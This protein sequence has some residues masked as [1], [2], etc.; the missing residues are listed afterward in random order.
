MT[1]ISFSS[2]FRKNNMGGKTDWVGKKLTSQSF[3]PGERMGRPILS[4]GKKLTGEKTDRYT[5]SG[6]T[7]C[8][9]II[10]DHTIWR[11]RG[12]DKLKLNRCI[13]TLRLTITWHCHLLVTIFNFVDAQ[14]DR[15]IE[16]VLLSTLNRFWSG[17]VG[18]YPHFT[19]NYLMLSKGKWSKG[20]SNY[21]SNY[22]P[23][24]KKGGIYRI[25]VVWP[26]VFRSY[27]FH[28]RLISW[29]LFYRIYPNFVCALIL[30][31][32]SL[33]LLH[34]IFPKFVPELRPLINAKILFQLNI[35]RTNWQSFTN[36]YI[37]I[38]ID[39]I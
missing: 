17:W 30:A 13:I 6:Q 9:G 1:H 16:T 36:F 25:W 21:L 12:Y 39:K 35:S 8:P 31:W 11:F 29:E 22:S 5:G 33:G 37:C 38:H 32:S 28:F 18:E 14:S 10:V 20:R 27:F 3:F 2:L 19:L 26:F 24:L 23:A 34:I 15:L 4:P 7:F